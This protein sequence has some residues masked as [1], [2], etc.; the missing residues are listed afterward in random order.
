MLEKGLVNFYLVMYLSQAS[1]KRNSASPS[2]Q[3]KLKHSEGHM[4]SYVKGSI[5]PSTTHCFIIQ[6]SP[7]KLF[8]GQL[9]CII[10]MV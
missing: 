9:R 3:D 7:G 8:N 2:D 1:K 5:H 6:P 10:Q 4:E